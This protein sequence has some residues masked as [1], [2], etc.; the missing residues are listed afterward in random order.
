[1]NQG[2]GKEP[3]L[4]VTNLKKHFPIMRGVLR[5]QVGA[6][7]AVDGVSFDIYEGETL[8]LVGESGCGK[9]TTGRVILQ[10]M[11]PTEGS[12]EFQGTELT[13]LK[14]SDMRKMRR[15]MQMIFQ[16]PYASLN[17]RMTVG[18]IVGEPLAIHGP[19]LP[20]RCSSSPT[21]LFPP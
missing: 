13:T 15:E 16:D 6:V 10:L 3:L 5:R 9:S 18:N 2:N 21:S 7:Q 14:K 19:W 8:G 20:I 4:K 11:A 17:P 1:M 12:V